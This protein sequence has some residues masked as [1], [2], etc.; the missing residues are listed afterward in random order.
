MHPIKFAFA[1]SLS[2]LAFC[3][4]ATPLT[5]RVGAQ[6]AASDALSHY[7]DTLKKHTFKNI[8][9]PRRALERNWEG[10]IQLK[11]TIDA[12]GQVQ[13]LQVLEESR[14]S[15][16][17]REALRS[18]ERANPYPPIPAELGINSYQFTVP[19]TFRLSQ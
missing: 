6:Q 8:K 19:I 17:N 7:V 1:L 2:A 12:K 14:Y 3:A 16:L 13:D 11:I 10:D 9:Y 5:A 4:Q 18:V 15:N